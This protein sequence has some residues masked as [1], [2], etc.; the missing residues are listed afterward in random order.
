MKIQK[1]AIWKWAYSNFLNNASRGIVAEFIVGTAID[2]LPAK[3]IEWDAYD[4]ETKTG[5]KIE[6][7]CSGYIQDWDQNEFSRISFDIEKKNSW[8]ARDNKYS[9]TKIRPSDFYC[10]CIHEEKVRD[11]LDPLDTDQWNFILVD[12]KA[13]NE[14]FGD[15]KTVSLSTLL[16]RGFKKLNFEELA[17]K[18]CEV[19]RY[20]HSAP[21]SVTST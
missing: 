17:N 10:F 14:A 16:K 18:A 1:E 3:R 5:V 4:L 15:Q 7:K 20:S 21:C 2:A 12:T 13:L 19:I 6:V 8:F 9:E 11:H